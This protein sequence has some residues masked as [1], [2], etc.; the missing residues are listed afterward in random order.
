MDIV[1]GHMSNAFNRVQAYGN[2]AYCFISYEHRVEMDDSRMSVVLHR[3]NVIWP[4]CCPYEHR[5]ASY[6]HCMT[7]T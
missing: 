6:E 5:A 1:L 7:L 3:M 4:S 2:R